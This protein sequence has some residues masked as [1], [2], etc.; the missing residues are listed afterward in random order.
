MFE[1]ARASLKER[2]ARWRN[3]R[4]E[5]KRRGLDILLV[6]SD[7]HIERAGS[8]RYVSDVNTRGMYVYLVFPLEGEPIAINMRGALNQAGEWVKNTRLLPLRG[9]WVPESEP[10]ALVVAEVIKEMNMEKGC[11]G[12]EGDF[13]PAPMYHRLVRELPNATFLQVDVIHELKRVKNPEEIRFVEKGAEMA[14]RGY[15]TCIQIARPG[16][17]WN[18]ITGEVCKTLYQWGMED[19]GGFPLSRS[20]QVMK[21]GDTYLLYPE[22]QAF[23]GYWIQFGR[24][25]SL[26]EPQKEVREAWDL[27]I[28]AQERGTEKLRPGNT[29]A[30]V[31]KAMRDALKGSKYTAAPRGCGHGVALD[32]LEKPFISFD[33]E[34]EL[35]PNMVMALHPIFSPPTPTPIPVLVADTYVVTDG[36]PRKL[37]KISP[38]IR[39]I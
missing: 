14:D 34:T 18:D 12:I 21:P 23:G 20:T 38:E 2:D 29:G 10:Y 37:S 4:E 36:E 7:G 5:L 6:L 32:V 30:D 28:M 25:I 8:I 16:K 3:I 11:I 19:I 35:K 26:G 33:D 31:I 15:E 27:S 1:M 13:I 24:L 17:T 39:I 22:T 9:G